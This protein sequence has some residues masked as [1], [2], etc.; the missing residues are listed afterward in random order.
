MR[1]SEPACRLPLGAW[2]RDRRST[3]DFCFVV[4]L[5][6]S[7][8][9]NGAVQEAN[10]N[11][12]RPA[13]QTWQMMLKPD[14]VRLGPAS[15]GND[16]L[17]YRSKMSRQSRLTRAIVSRQ[18]DPSATTPLEPYPSLFAKP[19]NA[20]LAPCCRQY[21]DSLT[22]PELKKIEQDGCCQTLHPGPL[23]ASLLAACLRVQGG[24]HR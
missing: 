1:T 24:V 4:V 8:V 2:L 16:C 15:I 17:P 13:L 14:P 21:G 9:L 12:P 7:R 11:V 5:Q 18:L 6:Q 19:A 20:D 10:A 23:G 22:R 3:D